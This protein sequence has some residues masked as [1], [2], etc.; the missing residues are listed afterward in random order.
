MNHFLSKSLVLYRSSYVAFAL[1]ISLRPF[2]TRSVSRNFLSAILTSANVSPYG[3]FRAL[4]AS[5]SIEVWRT[6][7][8]AVTH[9]PSFIG[10]VVLR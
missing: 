5:F 1:I 10:L 4:R 3:G 8:G 9:F 2:P 7:Y 6:Y